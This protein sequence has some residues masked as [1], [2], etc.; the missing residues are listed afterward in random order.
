MKN[1]IPTIK[2]ME[3]ELREKIR[4]CIKECNTHYQN[5]LDG[6]FNDEPKQFNNLC[7]KEQE[8]LV[9]F[10]H[11]CLG[12]AEYMRLKKKDI[13]GKMRVNIDLRKLKG[14]LPIETASGI[15]NLCPRYIEEKK[16]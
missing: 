2:R 15:D 14:S 13:R 10:F 5:W 3:K 9:A 8:R 11:S 4:F 7:R 12:E 6:E 1:Q 16:E